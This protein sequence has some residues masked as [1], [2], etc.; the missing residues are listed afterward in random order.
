MIDLTKEE[1]FGQTVA[2]DINSA[3]GCLTKSQG[4]DGDATSRNNLFPNG[5]IKHTVG[6]QSISIKDLFDRGRLKKAILSSFVVDFEFVLLHCLGVPFDGTAVIFLHDEQGGRILGCHP[7]NPNILVIAPSMQPNSALC[8]NRK[9]KCQT[10]YGIKETTEQQSAEP[11]SNLESHTLPSVNS[12]SNIKPS[13]VKQKKKRGVMHTKLMILFYEDRLRLV[14]TSANLIPVD[15]EHVQNVLYIHDLFL[16]NK[17]APDEKEKFSGDAD[18]QT[19]RRELEEYI[20]SMGFPDSSG[21]HSSLS[22]YDWSSVKVSLIFSS[23][24]IQG[25]AINGLCMLSE[26]ARKFLPRNIKKVHGQRLDVQGSSI[27][28]PDSQWE[29][30]FFSSISVPDT[31]DDARDFKNSSKSLRIIFPTQAYVERH[32]KEK[33]GT[34]FAPKI[35]FTSSSLRKFFCCQST[36][37]RLAPALHSK[38]IVYEAE[39]TIDNG[40]STESAPQRD[41]EDVSQDSD[42]VGGSRKFKWY[43]LGSANFTKSAW[44]WAEKAPNN[45]ELGILFDEQTCRMMGGFPLPYSTDPLPCYTDGD[46][47][48]SNS[49]F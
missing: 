31:A 2:S 32:G 4:S 10:E 26:K 6:P 45:W 29:S 11:N 20:N 37:S 13:A 48:W 46:L 47:P 49:I 24:T 30:Q 36:C 15:Y 42:G 23:P 34:I 17:T 41:N 35:R 16:K 43:Y 14:I 19:F 5:V 40:K 27:G 8:T 18:N 38:I 12:N 39:L 25:R 1:C 9:R 28:F 22:R 3:A 21:L 44:G 33:F 7:I